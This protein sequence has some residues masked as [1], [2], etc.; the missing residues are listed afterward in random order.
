MIVTF[1]TCAQEYFTNYLNLSYQNPLNFLED[2]MV[3]IDLFILLH[4]IG[5]VTGNFLREFPKR[6]SLCFTAVKITKT[7]LCFWGFVSS[8]L[9]YKKLFRKKKIIII[10]CVSLNNDQSEE[11]GGWKI[12]CYFK[13]CVYLRILYTF[14]C[15]LMFVTFVNLFFVHLF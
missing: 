8:F 5:I 11:S 1:T 3:R 2:L 13:F 15:I 7:F 10:I 9:K 12:L 4:N 14:C 6:I